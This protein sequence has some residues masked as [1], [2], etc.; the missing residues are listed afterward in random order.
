[1]SIAKKI[2]ED[3]NRRIELQ[4]GWGHPVNLEIARELRAVVEEI[5]EPLNELEHLRTEAA[6]NDQA[7]IQRFL[8]RLEWMAGTGNGIGYATVEKI[9]RFAI[10][11]GFLPKDDQS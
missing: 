8:N 7:V 9:R 3:L 2:V 4:T 6:Q 1:M 10:R 11:E 5:R